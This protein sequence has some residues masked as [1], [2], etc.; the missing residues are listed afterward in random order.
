MDALGWPVQSIARRRSVVGRIPLGSFSSGPFSLG[1][2]IPKVTAAGDLHRRSE[3]YRQTSSYRCAP[4]TPSLPGYLSGR[5]ESP[6][7]IRLPLPR[8]PVRSWLWF[9]EGQRSLFAPARLHTVDRDI[10]LLGVHQDVR[11]ATG[12]ALQEGHLRARIKLTEA[13]R[14]RTRRLSRQRAFVIK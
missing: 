11:Q 7:A 9:K 3:E 5:S 12:A 14:S 8:T 6:D 1:E 4:S 2:P 13:M 10:A